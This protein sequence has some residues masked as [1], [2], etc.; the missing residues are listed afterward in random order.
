LVPLMPASLV[1]LGPEGCQ[2]ALAPFLI[3]GTE[4]LD[5]AGGEAP[6]RDLAPSDSDHLGPVGLL[7]RVRFVQHVSGDLMKTKQDRVPEGA[8]IDTRHGE[9]LLSLL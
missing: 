9:Y 6:A 5:I 1:P 4:P 2:H 8:N 7:G 3:G